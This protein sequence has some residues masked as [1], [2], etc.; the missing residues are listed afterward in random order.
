MRCD[1]PIMITADSYDLLIHTYILLG[2]FFI[3]IIPRFVD[4]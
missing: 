1:G 4:G 2:Y 3:S